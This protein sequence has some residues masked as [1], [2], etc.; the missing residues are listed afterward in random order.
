MHLHV[1][2]ARPDERERA[3]LFYQGWDYHAGATDTAAIFVAEHHGDLV[4]LVRLEVELDVTVLRG[5]RVLPAHQ[6]RGIGSALLRTVADHLGTTPCYCIPFSHLIA[7]YGQVG[8]IELPVA[9]AP[10]HL[11]ARVVE[12]QARGR[13]VVL[14]LRRAQGQDGV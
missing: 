10:A 2:R 12:Y 13:D 4:G 3:A 7:F 14:M 8:F 6:R 1:R 11:Q 5:M 9:A